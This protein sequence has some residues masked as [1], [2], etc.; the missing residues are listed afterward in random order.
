MSWK[1]IPSSQEAWANDTRNWDPAG[2]FYFP[3]WCYFCN[4][5]TRLAGKLMAAICKMNFAFEEMEEQMYKRTYNL[6]YK[7]EHRIWSFFVWNTQFSSKTKWSI[8]QT[9][10]DISDSDWKC[11]QLAH[12]RSKGSTLLFSKRTVFF[13]VC[14]CF[15]FYYHLTVIRMFQNVPNKDVLGQLNPCV[16]FRLFHQS[17]SSK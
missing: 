15:K 14:K 7:K 16:V 17:F 10:Y 2:W 9:A 11:Y 4:N 8:S 5:H 3:F 6:V 1:R 12:T 13:I